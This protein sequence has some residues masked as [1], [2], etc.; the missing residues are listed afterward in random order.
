MTDREISQ[1][2]EKVNQSAFI[3]S[4]KDEPEGGVQNT[5]GGSDGG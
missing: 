1:P 4:W 3:T 2:Q 5:K